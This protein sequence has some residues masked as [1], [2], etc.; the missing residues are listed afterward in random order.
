MVCVNPLVTVSAESVTVAPV[1]FVSVAVWAALA[2]PSVSGLN[3]SDPGVNIRVPA[4]ALPLSVTVCGLFAALSVNVIVSFFAPL[5]TGLKTTDKVHEVP[6]SEDPGGGQVFAVMAKSGPMEIESMTTALACE[7]VNVSVFGPEVLPTEM[8]PQLSEEGDSV[9]GA[10]IPVPT[11]FAVCAAFEA[12]SL[13]VSVP[14]KGPLLCGVKL[15]IIVQLELPASELPQVSVSVKFAP[16]VLM[17]SMATAVAPL[18]VSVNVTGLLLLPTKTEPK[19][20]LL[21]VNVALPVFGF[22][23]VAANASVVPVPAVSFTFTLPLYGPMVVGF[24][25]TVTVQVAPG[26]NDPIGQLLVW[27]NAPLMVIE[28]NV[29]A[30][31]DILVNVEVCVALVLY[32]AVAAKFNEPG[33][34]SSVPAVPVPLSTAVCGLFAALS[35]NVSGSLFLPVEVGRKITETV[36]EAFAA[37]C[38]GVAGQVLAEI[39]KSGPVVIELIATPAL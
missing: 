29:T 16:P 27:V 7:F 28:D 9:T 21:G 17:P 1:V 25:A 10:A 11:N 14:V 36:Q 15:T 12:S 4:V 23:P 19:S 32:C 6:D 26:A 24:A 34:N 37:T 39:A 38:V 5:E 30:A 13:T 2:V 35:L 31:A 3:V 18:F 8:L 33:E 20:L 22:V